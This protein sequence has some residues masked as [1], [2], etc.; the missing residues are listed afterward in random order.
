MKTNIEIL[1]KDPLVY[2]IYQK[3]L[4]IFGIESNVSKYLVV[5][6]KCYN[7]PAEFRENSS[8]FEFLNIDDWFSK[9]LNCDILAWQ[10]SCL[11]RKFVIKEHVKLTL[12]VDATKLRKNF[13]AMYDPYVI[14]AM[15]EISNGNFTNGRLKLLEILKEGD[16]SNQ[17]ID[18]HKIINFSV[19][20]SYYNE[21]MK[22]EDNEEAIFKKFVEL[23]SKSV[24]NFI[25][26]TDPLVRSNKLKKINNE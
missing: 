19:I 20:K 12:S 9:V 6:D 5:V 14:F 26:R 15:S 24:S 22:T 16:F 3:D 11:N 1:K 13:N 8:E 2:Y 18:F 23:Q 7:I 25:K 4:S 21:L 10:C 17:V